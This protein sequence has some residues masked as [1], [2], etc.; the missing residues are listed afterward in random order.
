MAIIHLSP[1]V[2]EVTGVAVTV[3]M[4]MVD[5]GTVAIMADTTMADITA[6]VAVDFITTMKLPEEG[7]PK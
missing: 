6:V 1:S 2:M 4:D 3:D 7:Q 5:M